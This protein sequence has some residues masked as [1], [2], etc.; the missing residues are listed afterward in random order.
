[1]LDLLWG[2][3]MAKDP[4]SERIRMTLGILTPAERKAQRDAEIRRQQEA[5]K[6]AAKGV[7]LFEEA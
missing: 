3:L 7:A 2:T 6:E 5:D 1:M 4:K